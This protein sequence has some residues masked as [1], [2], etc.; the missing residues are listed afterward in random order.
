MATIHFVKDG[1][2]ENGESITKDVDVPIDWA[3][4]HLAQSVGKRHDAPPP[5]NPNRRASDYAD[6]E[7]V[8]LEV[9]ESEACPS[10]PSPGYYHIG[11]SPGECL[12]LLAA[13]T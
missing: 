2:R 3:A 7:H 13:G 5:F 4:K 11:L 8:V 9:S 12:R 6:Y 10:F 1:V